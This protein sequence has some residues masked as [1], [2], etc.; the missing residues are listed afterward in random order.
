MDQ[1]FYALLGVPRDATEKDI[2]AAYR[3]LARKLH[4]DMN[5]GNAAA[6][7]KFKKVN[8]A[9][10]VL[11]EA[12]S[13]RDY[14][15]FGEHWKHADEIRSSNLGAA[16]G[17][18][19]FPFSSSGGRRRQTQA[20]NIFD[21]FNFSQEDVEGNGF[22]ARQQQELTAEITLD[23]AHHGAERLVSIDNGRGRPRR[24]EV[25]IPA[26]IGDGGRVR[27]RPDTGA[28]LE[29]VVRIKPDAR[30]RREGADLHADVPVPLID[31][32]LGGE[33]QV[34]TMTGRVALKLPA[35]TQ[36]GRSFRL[37][38]KG[39]P[40]LGSPGTFGDLIA[41]LKVVL[42]EKLSDDERAL[43]EQLRRSRDGA[44]QGAG[45]R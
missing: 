15:E 40:R 20:G 14:N 32:V 43:F 31:A 36:N 5:P 1:D 23:E 2:R 3:K 37:T 27:I 44:V 11:S 45:P 35:G 34:A 25:K 24:L 10:E 19:G 41:T 16:G 29:I 9:Y 8:E 39:M 33:V 18:G 38:G 28:D 21:L 22:G 30:F 17:H 26:G 6:E 7:A 42:P 13:R 4:P 12:K